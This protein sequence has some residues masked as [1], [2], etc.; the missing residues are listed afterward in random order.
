MPNEKNGPAATVGSQA[1][2]VIPRI[3]TREGVHPF[4]QIEWE[5]RDAVI[6][7]EDG[8]IIFEQKGVEFP[9]SWSQSAGQIVASKYFHGS[10]EHRENSLRQL[11]SRVADTIADWG[12]KGGY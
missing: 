2:L 12:V 6:A 7:D 10:S 5:K 9:K 8:K 11:V 3:F 1:G 4:D